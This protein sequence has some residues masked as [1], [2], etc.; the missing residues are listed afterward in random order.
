[1]AD[2]NYIYKLFSGQD[3]VIWIDNLR[4]FSYYFDDNS[5]IVLRAVEVDDFDLGT[6]YYYEWIISEAQWNEAIVNENTITF[7]LDT[8]Y[9]LVLSFWEEV[10]VELTTLLGEQLYITNTH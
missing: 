4:L 1:M 2:K 5:A 8:G 9:P 3:Y 7:I 10:Q 6:N